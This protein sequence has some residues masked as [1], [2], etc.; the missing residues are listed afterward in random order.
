MIFGKL[1]FERSSSC[2]FIAIS[3]LSFQEYRGVL[4]RK[5]DVWM[6]RIGRLSIGLTSLSV[7][8]GLGR[9]FGFG[10]IRREGN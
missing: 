2:P 7:G 3:A 5:G 10:I 9:A 8:L 1:F 6:V 4:S